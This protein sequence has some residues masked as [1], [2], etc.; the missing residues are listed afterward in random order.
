M[1]LLKFKIYLEV[2]NNIVIQTYIV[3]QKLKESDVY[4]RKI[5]EQK[6]LKFLD[7]MHR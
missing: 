2:S 3:F 1:C 7:K 6:L 5:Y 4:E